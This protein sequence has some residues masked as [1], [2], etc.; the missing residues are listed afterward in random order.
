MMLDLVLAIG[1]HVLAFLLAALLAME[2]AII[3]PGLRRADLPRLSRIDG[4]Y[5][6]VAAAIIVVGIG[7]VV[8]GLKGWEYYVFYPVFWAKMAAFAIVGLLSI[9]PTIRIARWRRAAGTD[10]VPDEEI[11][12]L[13]NFLKAE[14]AVF[15][16]IPIF[17]AVM[18]R[19]YYA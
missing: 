10:V 9:A 3:R 19:G 16:L 17:A 18:A 8:F 1:H 7:R 14:A 15:V 6:A 4:L 12:M 5:G 2:F 13:R 11:R